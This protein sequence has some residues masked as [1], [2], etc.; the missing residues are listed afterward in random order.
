MSDWLDS[1][2]LLCVSLADSEFCVMLR[3]YHRVCSSED[4]E[5]NYELIAP[6]S[7]DR[8]CFPV[9]SQG[10]RPFFYAYDCFFGPMSITFPFTSF[11]TDLLW[12][13]NVAPS[14]LHPNSWGFIKIF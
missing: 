9:L 8:V 3:R 1:L 11:E 14:Q 10:E 13:C 5:S 4:Q 12:S 7:G 2:V 6:D